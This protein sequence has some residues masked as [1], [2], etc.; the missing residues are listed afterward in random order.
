MQTDK[1]LMAGFE[2]SHRNVPRPILAIAGM[3]FGLG[4]IVVFPFTGLINFILSGGYRAK[5]SLA[6][7]GR[8][9]CSETGINFSPA[10]SSSSPCIGQVMSKHG[11][12]AIQVL[13]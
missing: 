2:D 12:E 8:T 1:S 10:F 9:A 6:S 5:Q 13:Q 11:T 3:F 4:Y 7:L